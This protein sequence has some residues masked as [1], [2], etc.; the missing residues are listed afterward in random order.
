[1]VDSGNQISNGYVNF[2]NV[3]KTMVDNA[4]ARPPQADIQAYCWRTANKVGFNIQ[5]KNLS[6]V[7]L[8]S[9]NSATVHAIV[10]ED[11]HVKVTN[12]FA[13][14]AVDQGISNLAPNATATFTLETPDLSNVIWD[15]LHFVVLVDYRPS[16]SVG[17]FDTL[18]AAIA[19]PLD[20]TPPSVVSSVRADPNP[21]TAASI[22]FTVTFSE[23]VTGVDT[24]DFTLTVTGVTGAS[25]TSVS[26]GPT[27]YTVNVNTGT[28]SGTLRLN[29]VDND[30]I[31][32]G[33]SNSL[34]GVG[35]GNGSFTDGETYTVSGMPIFADVPFSYWAMSWIERLYAAG[36][37][38]GCGTNPLTYCPEDS[39]TRA[40][41][42]IFL[43]RGMNGSAFTP[44][45]GT[46]TVF[47]DVPLSYWAVNW[48][49]KLFA[50]SITS[51]CGTNPLIYCPDNPVTRSQM[52]VFLLRAKHGAA[53]VPPAAAGIFTDV[54]A[55][56]WAAKWI[57]QLYA[58]GITTGCLTSP[59]L[60][61]PED[62]VTRAEMAVFLVQMFNLP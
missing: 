7:T 5:V 52:A 60:Y 22:R 48:I 57:E 42:A 4:L 33:S 38:G 21:T 47:A 45:A 16:G 6:A 58:E 18:Q 44:P 40:Q 39:V 30:S 55:S 27:A 10:Y 9:S 25:I 41:M 59:L 12:R 14:A 23:A 8:S 51:G 17:A 35:A 50:D 2:Y 13:R 34:G 49:E 26:G 37:T 15:N 53:H 11:A 28:G 56:Y 46:G 62:S 54:P 24:A 32:D 36:I 19:L 43:E 20:T 61:C 3:Y 29:V 1:M 31:I